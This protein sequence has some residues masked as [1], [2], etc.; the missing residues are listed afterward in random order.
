MG[1]VG[2]PFAF[3][4]ESLRWRQTKGSVYKPA[5]A[6]DLPKSGVNPLIG[7]ARKDVILMIDFALRADCRS[8]KSNEL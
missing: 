4:I 3:A 6:L 2:A 8:Q 1:C 5:L 7:S